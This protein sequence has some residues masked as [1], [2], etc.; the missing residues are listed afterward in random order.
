MKKVAIL[1][2]NY[3]PWKGYFD[4][5]N[6]VDEFI[7]YDDMQYT[8]RDW[9]NRNKIKTSNG[10]QWLTIPV[11]V[12]GK[13]SQAIKDTKI[14]DSS[15]A[16]KHWNAIKHSYSKSKYFKDY[17]DIFEQLYLNS[18]EDSLSLINHKFIIAINSILNI[19]TKI[20]WSSDFDLVDGKTERLLG[21]CKDCEATE[22]ISGSAA[23]GY[24]AESLF[25][26]ENIKV[27]W[28]EYSDYP[29]YMQ[30]HPPFDHAV[31]I[32]DLIFNEGP[33]SKNYMKSFKDIA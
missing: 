25:E 15:W 23:Q 2:S 9:R 24:L 19:K 21:I 17:K 32:L 6:M 28:M 22:Y 7:L 10:V 20:L 12:K 4:I 1:Q 31:T 14:N 3:I 26:E 27:S 11:D 30:L 8:R 13:Y 16:Q 5:I 29:D 18:N 33:Y